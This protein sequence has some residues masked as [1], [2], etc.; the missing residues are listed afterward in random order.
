MSPRRIW[1]Q[2]F[3]VCVFFALTAMMMAPLL[4]DPQHATVGQEGDNCY[5]I[6]QLWWMKRAVIDLHRSPYFDPGTYYP[7]GHSLAHSELFPA[8]SI[9]IIPVTAI[10]GP[11]TAYNL[12][13]FLTFVLTGYGTYRWLRILTGAEEGALVAGIIAAFLPYRMAHA[14]GHLDLASTHWIPW[15]LFAHER[16]LRSRTLA[17]ALV[18]GGLIGAVALSAWYYAYAAAWLLPLYAIVRAREERLVRDR[19][20]QIGMAGAALV[21]V[22]MTLP[23]LIPYARLRLEGGLVRT[24]DEMDGWSLNV[25]AFFLPNRLNPVWTDFMTRWFYQDAFQ[26]PERGVSLG[27]TAIALALAGVA[28]ARRHPAIAAIGAVWIASFLIALGPTLHA[29]DRQVRLPIPRTV[30]IDTAEHSARARGVRASEVVPDVAVPLPAMAMYYFIPITS[31]MRVMARFGFWTG[32]MTAA[33]AAWG[34]QR[35]IQRR[36]MR[37]RSIVAAVAALVLAE[38]YSVFPVTMVRPRAVDSWLR[39]LPPGNWSVVELPVGQGRRP[40]QDYYK[41]VHQQ[42]TVFGSQA[43]GFM[44]SVLARRLT[45]LQSFPSSDALA[46]LRI[47]RTRYVLFTPGEIAEWPVLEKQID[48]IPD[49]TF[50]RE[51]EGVRVYVL[52]APAP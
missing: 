45:A 40:L 16:F 47:A 32:L 39:S 22:A 21:A 51:L 50:D 31:A 1:R 36:P 30:A 41:T 12:A 38:S 15:A 8:T 20:W 19:P 11:V 46:M 7:I 24:L 6:R 48:A 43:D 33:L 2:P 4:R 42:P 26:W 18:F 17:R 25:Y 14:L 3:I 49:L 13:L 23:F 9:P 27:Y 35:L 34:V 5:G 29:R 10:W 37:S 44:S 28:S 52:H